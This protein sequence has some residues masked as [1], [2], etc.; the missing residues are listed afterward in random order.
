M[1]K[2]NCTTF[3]ASRTPF[4]ARTASRLFKQ[5]HEGAS[6][7]LDDAVPS[8]VARAARRES[9]AFGCL[10]RGTTGPPCEYSSAADWVPLTTHLIVG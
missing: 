2:T 8:W 6:L 7:I 3:N 5:S 10:S 1:S 9:S 4:G